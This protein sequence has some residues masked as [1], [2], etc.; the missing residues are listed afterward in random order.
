MQLVEAVGRMLDLAKKGPQPFGLLADRVALIYEEPV[1]FTEADVMQAIRTEGEGGDVRRVLGAQL[2]RWDFDDN[3][4]WAAGTNRSSPARRR[5]I[6][7]LMQLDENARDLLDDR[8]PHFVIDSPTVIDARRWQPWYTPARKAGRTFYWD[9]L[10]RHLHGPLGWPEESVLSL[11]ESTDAVVERLADPLNEATYQ[12]KGLVV[13]YVQSGKTANITGVVAKAAD[14]GCRLVIV[15]AGTLNLLRDQTQRRID[16]E[17]VGREILEDEYA[18]D[19]DWPRFL[20]H[21]QRPSQLGAFDWTR[22]TGRSRDYRTLSGGAIES[23]RFTRSDPGVPFNHPDNLYRAPAKLLVVKKQAI[24]LSKLARDLARINADGALVN[25]PALVIDDES[26]QASVNT[27]R[28]VISDD[29]ETERTRIN[30][31]IVGLLDALPRAQYIGYTATPFANVFVDPADAADLFPRDFIVGLPRPN[32]YL[33]ASDFHDLDGTPDGAEDN[34]FVSNEAAFVRPVYGDDADESNLLRAIDS[35]L[36]A[37]A[38]KLYRQRHDPDLDFRH[39]TLMIHT[40]PRTAEHQTQLQITRRLLEVSGYRLGTATNR[41]RELFET[42]FAPVSATRSPGLPF[43]RNF[44]DLED[45]LGEVLTRLYR[46]G[47]AVLLV[48]STREANQ[49]AFDTEPVWKIIVGGAKLSRGFTVEGLTTS[50]FRRRSPTADTL[51]QM[52]R[53]CGFRRGYAD[54][55][56]LFIGRREPQGRENFDVYEAFEAVCRDEEAFRTELRRYA[57]PVDGGDPITPMEVPPLVATHLEW[58]RPTNRNKMFNAQ[59][60]YRNFGGEWSEHRRVAQSIA[61]RRHNESLFRRLIEEVGLDEFDLAAGARHMTAYGALTAA[62]P[63]RAALAAYLWADGLRDLQQELE[64]L[65]G[66]HGDPQIDDWLL[67]LPQL[68]RITER[69]WAIDGKSVSVHRRAYWNGTP[70]LVNAYAGPD[71]RALAEMVTGKRTSGE[72]SSDLKRLRAARRAVMIVYP[73]T[74][75]LSEDPAWIPTIGLSLLF[76]ANDIPRQI[77]FTVRRPTQSGEPV[78]DAS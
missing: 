18:D 22:L 3:P 49:L 73:I 70:P 24:V 37:G 48:N 61:D 44:D 33:G 71:D 36:L 32:G 11:D 8:L 16:R 5:R 6:Y 13:G 74:H 51:M 4:S 27:I 21:G 50:Y 12:A 62:E 17:L 10:C 58:V 77:G 47:D 23:M 28:P 59:I 41:L 54:L 55:V 31:A 65:Y 30:N 76:P 25:V 35:F 42:D 78:I 56:R 7:D 20:S 69:T 26:D 29:G 38:I 67:L 40:S 34:R 68:T 19:S 43:P 45:D 53:W 66:Q 57:M 39:H 52:G 15:L 14:A 60:A 72:P 63:V 75:E 2:A 64:F 1:T 9:A 46:G